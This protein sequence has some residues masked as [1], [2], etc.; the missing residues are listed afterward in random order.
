MIKMN[1]LERIIY[2]FLFILS[3]YTG[4]VFLE[5]VLNWFEDIMIRKYIEPVEKIPYN[6]PTIYAENLTDEIFIKL[7]NN[8]K[9]PVLIKKYM[10]DT[11]AVNKWNLPYL[12]NIIGDFKINTIKY[13]DKF[14]LENISFKNFIDRIRDEDIYINNNH[15]ILGHFPQLFE[16]IRPKFELMLK[17]LKSCNLKSIHF[18]NLFIGY[19]NDLKKCTGSNM[20][21]AGSSNLFCMLR[22]KKHWTLIHPKYSYLLKPRV[23]S[24]G[25]HAQTLFD[26]G[27]IELDKMPKIFTYLPRYEVVMEAGDV[28]YNPPWWWHR[29]RNYDGLSIGIAIR[30]NKVTK[31]NLLNN[32]TFTLSGYKYLLYNTLI[33]EFY[34]RFMGGNKHFTVSKSENGSVLYEIEKLINKYPKSTDIDIILGHKK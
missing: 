22:G 16:D 32:L 34:E 7:S 1:F 25:I 30:N 9:D 21:C 2:F 3:K 14:E 4:L 29:I 23:A 6:I 12:E 18:A 19:N 26:M 5:E 8:Y 11:D 24:T 33:L 20:H 27:D 28:L 17:T 10:K 13:T 31:I 15:T